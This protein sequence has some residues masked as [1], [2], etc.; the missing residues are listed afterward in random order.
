M[1][2]FVFGHAMQS[3][4]IPTYLFYHTNNI[5][6]SSRVFQFNCQCLVIGFFL[7]L[8]PMTYITF[9]V[10]IHNC[11]SKF[12][13]VR[14][15][16]RVQVPAQN[17]QNPATSFIKIECTVLLLVYFSPRYKIMVK[18]K[19]YSVW[20]FTHGPQLAVIIIKEDSLVY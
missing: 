13:R 6:T 14:Q 4:P 18:L 7:L 20:G 11:I 10:P 15:R 17:T 1:Q 16:T 3:K 5:I 19:M 8:G 9:F 2:A 12:V